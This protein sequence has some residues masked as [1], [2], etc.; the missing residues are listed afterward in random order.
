M[1]FKRRE[2]SLHGMFSQP[3]QQGGKTRTNRKTI[4][5]KTNKSKVRVPADEG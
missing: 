4:V 3:N 1:G 5:L 2:K